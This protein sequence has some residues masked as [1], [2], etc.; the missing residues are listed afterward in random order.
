MGCK[1]CKI[2]H[3]LTNLTFICNNEIYVFNKKDMHTTKNTFTQQKV[4]VCNESKYIDNKTLPCAAKIYI[5]Q[6]I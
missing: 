5:R 4:Y 6:Y 3:I 1:G 2:S